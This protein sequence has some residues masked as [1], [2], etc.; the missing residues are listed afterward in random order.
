[1]S[2]S[3][4]SIA[5]Y[6]SYA[7]FFLG[8]IHDVATPIIRSEWTCVG[9]ASVSALTY[10]SF[11]C[12]TSFCLCGALLCSYFLPAFANA[13]NEEG[14]RL[15]HTPLLI[16]ATFLTMFGV[17][18]VYS[19]ISNPF[20][21]IALALNVSES[22]VLVMLVCTRRHHVDDQHSTAKKNAD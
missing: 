8:V 6:L 22:I 3:L 21:W 18:A 16:I 7:I 5:K 12:G 15:L 4:L 14:K 11:C 13:A 20:A 17:S 1:M 10:M 19:M 9:V 2:T